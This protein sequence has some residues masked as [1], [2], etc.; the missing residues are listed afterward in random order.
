MCSLARRVYVRYDI[1]SLFLIET[2]E[3]VALVPKE[4]DDEWS[5]EKD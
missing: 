1:E 5:T 2:Q 4:N 3:T